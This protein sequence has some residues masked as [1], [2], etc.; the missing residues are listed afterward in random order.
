MVAQSVDIIYDVVR[1]HVRFVDASC[2]VKCDIKVIDN[3]DIGISLD[4]QTILL[5]TE[6][7]LLVATRSCRSALCK[8]QKLVYLGEKWLDLAD[9]GAQ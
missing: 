5:N 3:L 6:T 2:Q 4:L 7:N 1:F 8:S 9:H